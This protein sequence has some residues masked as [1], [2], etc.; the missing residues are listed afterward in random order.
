MPRTGAIS[1]QQRAPYDRLQAAD[2]ALQRA[3]PGTHEHAVR[4]HECA[5][6]YRE[7]ADGLSSGGLLGY[8]H[9]ADGDWVVADAWAATGA[10]LPEF[11]FR[12][13]HM[14]AIR[15]HEEQVYLERHG[16]PRDDLVVGI[17][18]TE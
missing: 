10:L 2:E 16:R 13:D 11:D 6:R 18:G 3:K 4:L 15:A 12:G 9:R 14:E 17:G 8:S 5:L 1:A 7:I